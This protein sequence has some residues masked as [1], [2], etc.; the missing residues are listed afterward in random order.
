MSDR[1]AIP[2]GERGT[3]A[4]LARHPPAARVAEPTPGADAAALLR[5]LQPTAGN[6]A[7]TALVRGVQPRVATVQRS[8][9][10]AL[11]RR[12]TAN[13]G[14]DT[15]FRARLIQRIRNYNTGDKPHD[16]SEPYLNKRMM[17]LDGLE[18]DLYAWFED[19]KQGLGDN[20]AAPSLFKLMNSI[21]AE[22]RKVVGARVAAGHGL[23]TLDE[24]DA[25]ERAEIDEVWDD[26][27]N[28]RGAFKI[29]ADVHTL[30]GDYLAL[31]EALEPFKEEIRRTSRA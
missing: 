25:E 18:H 30:S 27:V 10:E 2:A 23:W 17:L 1:L 4:R 29:K 14:I 5:V 8:L 16:H 22:H 3:A 24:S 13:A 6:R 20:P 7:V 19:N 28:F 31:G 21:Q 26:I 11:V 15:E 12:T 9:D